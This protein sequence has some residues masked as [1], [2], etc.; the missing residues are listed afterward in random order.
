MLIFILLYL[1]G[2]IWKDICSLKIKT[3]SSST[4]SIIHTISKGFHSLS[5]CCSYRKFCSKSDVRECVKEF[6]TKSL[7][8]RLDFQ[9]KDIQELNWKLNFSFL[10]AHHLSRISLKRRSDRNTTDRTV[11][12]AVEQRTQCRLQIEKKKRKP[13]RKMISVSAQTREL[14]RGLTLELKRVIRMDWRVMKWIRN[15]Q[16]ERPL[17]HSSLRPL[18]P[19]PTKMR[20]TFDSGI[21]ARIYFRNFCSVCL[22]VCLSAPK[23]RHDFKT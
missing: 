17:D 2:S 5:K 9:W 6:T 3:S 7:L 4:V 15:T 20:H 8:L 13:K 16:R 22:T 18:W 12:T 19:T 1:K 23:R 10:F 14:R 21:E 11:R